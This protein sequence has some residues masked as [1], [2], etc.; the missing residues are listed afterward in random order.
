M[1]LVDDQPLVRAG[2]RRILEP[3]DGIAIVGECEDGD[4]VAAAVDRC[5][6][7]VVV[8]DVR[9][10]RMDGAEATR[11]LRAREG[12]PPVLILTTF[13]DD[14]TVAAAL[15]AGA[16]GFV[17]KDAPGE[18]I[19]RAT[20]T[21]AEGGSWLDPQVV[22]RVLDAYRRVAGR[23]GRA[24]AMTDLLTQREHDVLRHVGRGATNAEVAAALHVSEATVKSHLG[25]ILT[26]LGLRDRSAAIVFA[27]DQG[28]V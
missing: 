26:K 6:P 19:V 4:Q 25:R 28:L 15:G 1:L 14:D 20:T 2:L 8:M 9:M 27:H 23:H 18:D 24:G 16:A 10:R 3:Q 7:D 5:R 22:G 11:R 21:V 13:D 17:L 12:A